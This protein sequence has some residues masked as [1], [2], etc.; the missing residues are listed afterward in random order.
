MSDEIFCPY[1]EQGNDDARDKA[2]LYSD[3]EKLFACE[4]CEKE[5]YLMWTYNYHV[6]KIN[7]EN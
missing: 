6:R 4:Y 2:P 5:F 3:V 1:C 7:K